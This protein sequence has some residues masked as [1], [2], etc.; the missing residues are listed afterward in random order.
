MEVPKSDK[1][2]KNLIMGLTCKKNSWILQF[3][4]FDPPYLEDLHPSHK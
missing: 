4:L 2:D 1:K 3:R